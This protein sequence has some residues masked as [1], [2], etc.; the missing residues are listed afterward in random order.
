[1]KSIARPLLALGVLAMLLVSAVYAEEKDTAADH[2]AQENYDEDGVPFVT[3]AIFLNASTHGAL[4]SFPAGS[5]VTSV[6]AYQNAARTGDQQVI[7]VAAYLQPAGKFSTILQNFSVVRQ[8]RT[9][10]NKET[11]TFRYSFVP[12]ASFEPGPYNLVVGVFYAGTASNATDF[13]TAYNSTVYIA[14]P[15]STDPRTVLTYLTLLGIFGAIAYYLAD[16]F[17][18]IRAINESQRGPAKPTH[19]L[20]PVEV[21]AGKKNSATYDPDYVSKEHTRYRDELLRKSSA[22]PKKKN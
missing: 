21:E 18:V 2:E 12:D 15:L 1:M 17:G 6:I 13:A 14:E 5:P 3:R 22:S 4:P 9:V 10:E 11:A 20:K 7:L 16:R 19:G 8:A